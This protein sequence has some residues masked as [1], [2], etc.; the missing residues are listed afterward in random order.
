LGIE[1]RAAGKPNKMEN[2]ETLLATIT[3]EIDGK[4]AKMSTPVDVLKE[5]TRSFITHRLLATLQE[6]S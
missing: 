1:I 4:T 3:L 5:D 6:G 2:V